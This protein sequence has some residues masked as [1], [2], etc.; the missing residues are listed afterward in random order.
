MSKVYNFYV[1]TTIRGYAQYRLDDDED[2]EEFAQM[3]EGDTV[4]YDDMMQEAD[5]DV[6]TEVND[7]AENE[8]KEYV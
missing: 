4:T 7:F 1:T 2:P 5:I 8:G 3:L 6:E